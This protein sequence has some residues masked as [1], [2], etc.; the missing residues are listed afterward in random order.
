[1]LTVGRGNIWILSRDFE[2][3]LLTF[4]LKFGTKDMQADPCGVRVELQFEKTDTPLS[5]KSDL[6]GSEPPT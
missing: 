5:G 2:V 6:D 4:A 1:M 3:F